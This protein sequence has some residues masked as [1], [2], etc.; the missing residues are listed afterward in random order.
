[1]GG[2]GG[3]MRSYSGGENRRGKEEREERCSHGSPVLS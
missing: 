3:W 1:M 2:G